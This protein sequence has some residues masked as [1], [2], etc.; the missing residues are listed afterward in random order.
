MFLS[1]KILHSPSKVLLIILFLFC[2][3]TYNLWRSWMA[4]KH[5]FVSDVSAYYS[6]FD[7]AFMHHDLTFS[8]PNNHWLVKTNTNKVVPK[9]SMGLAMVYLPGFFVCHIA[10][11]ISGNPI[12]IY[13]AT[14]SYGMYYYAIIFVFLGLFALRKVLLNYYSE[15]VTTYTLLAIFIGTNLFYYSV[16]F[17]LMPHSFLFT[18]N[19]WLIALTIKLYNKPSK[20]TTIGIGVL[21]GLITLIRPTG[22]LVS[23]FVFLF[24]C[25]TWVDIK[26]RFFWWITNWK[27][28]LAIAFL[29]LLVWSPQLYYWKMQSGEYFFYSYGQEGFN[30]LKPQLL[31]VFF[32][33]RKG[34][35]VYTPIMSFS[36]VGFYFLYKQKSAFTLST[37]ALITLV[38]YVLSCWWCW[39]WGGSFSIRAFVDYYP[40]LAFPLAAFFK[41]TIELM[42]SKLAIGFTI[43]LIAFNLLQTYQYTTVVIH[44][45]NMTKEAYL[46]SL[47]KLKYTN[48][49]RAHFNTLLEV[50]SNEVPE[51]Y[52]RKP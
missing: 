21:I 32:S 43:L 22:A 37:L 36:L 44:W 15:K 12:D 52:K 20:L 29:T 45:D 46:F 25:T 48:E 2:G 6:Y 19:V 28:I 3:L 27:N 24:G 8:Y 35:L 47:G 10:N 49:E 13:N 7:A 23:V 40:Y 30:F 16:S 14:Y 33:F 42:K 38:F 26:T 18:L 4:S 39:S 50:H 11:I 31:N 9:M 51:D 41:Q 34:W 17:N 1:K 5:P